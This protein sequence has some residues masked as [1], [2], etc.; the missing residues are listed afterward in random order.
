MALVWTR[1]KR[2]ARRIGRAIRDTAAVLHLVASPDQQSILVQNSN[3][4]NIAG[5]SEKLMRSETLLL[6]GIR[7][8]VQ[9]VYR[10]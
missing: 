4:F 10:G 5:R 6:A 2:E 7:T 8:P 3:D 1:R 9:I